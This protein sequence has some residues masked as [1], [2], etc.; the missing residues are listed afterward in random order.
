MTRIKIVQKGWEGFSSNL[1]TTVFKDGIAECDEREAV[2]IGAIVQ[3][4]RLDDEDNEDG[5]INV[6]HEITLTKDLSAEIQ[7]PLQTAEALAKLKAEEEPDESEEAE[8]EKD[9]V[10]KWT[11]ESLEKIADEN[12]IK[13]L[14]E[15]GEPL[16]VKSTKISELIDKILEVQNAA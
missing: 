6:G 5:V 2:R 16:G 9:P 10:V 4:M 7:P 1:G 15:I 13:G 12:G 14:R 8:T 3:I 11:E